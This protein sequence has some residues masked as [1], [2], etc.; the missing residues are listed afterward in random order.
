MTVER[1]SV[2]MQGNVVGLVAGE[3]TELALV[4]KQIADALEQGV[5]KRSP[6]RQ[7]GACR[8]QRGAV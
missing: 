6:G 4:L 8:S 5:A 1:L 2:A 7:S 3:Y